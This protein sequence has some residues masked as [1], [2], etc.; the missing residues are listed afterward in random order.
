M[1][2]RGTIQ[3]G[4]VVPDQALGLPDGHSV[5]IVATPVPSPHRRLAALGRLR[6]RAVPVALPDEAFDA[7]RLYDDGP[8]AS[9]EE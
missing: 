2:I 5:Y 1:V 3:N 8:I 4:Y 9:G 7:E 6:A